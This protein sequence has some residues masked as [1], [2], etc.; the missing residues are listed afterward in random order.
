MGTGGTTADHSVR[1]SAFGACARRLQTLP[2]AHPRAPHRVSATGTHAAVCARWTAMAPRPRTASVT[3]A[4]CRVD[5]RSCSQMP[6]MTT[7]KGAEA[8]RTSEARPLGIPAA[9]PA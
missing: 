4:S 1:C 8:C 7:V 5:S 2:I 6:P 3:P 9:M